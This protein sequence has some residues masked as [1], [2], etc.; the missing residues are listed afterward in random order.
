MAGQMH[1]MISLRMMISCVCGLGL[2]VGQEFGSRCRFVDGQKEPGSGCRLWQPAA[3][4]AVAR[5]QGPPPPVPPPP[6][7]RWI[8]HQVSQT[9]M[10][11]NTATAE[12]QLTSALQLLTSPG[13]ASASASAAHGVLPMHVS[14][15]VHTHVAS[16]VACHDQIG[17][18]PAAR[19]SCRML[20]GVSMKYAANS[21]GHTLPYASPSGPLGQGRLY[22][23]P[24]VRK[25]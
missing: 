6:A 3:M 16:L 21:D 23:R 5:F 20:P 17:L 11:S 1:M 15:G 8:R 12:A 2:S 9:A 14:W 25:L 7:T 10:A 4:H 18:C 13:R 22:I 19:P 24:H